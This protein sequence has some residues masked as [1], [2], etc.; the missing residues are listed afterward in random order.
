MNI[1]R[2]WRLVSVSLAVVFLT[3]GC[4]KLE[5]DIT[6]ANDD[7]VSGTMVF[8]IAK[9]ITD[10][11]AEDAESSPT[12]STQELFPNNADIESKPF[13]DGEFVGTTYTFDD[14][15]LAELAPEVGDDSALAIKR[16]G[17]NLVVSGLLDTGS[18][19][20]DLAT[21]PLAASL[22]EGIAELTSIKIAITLPGDIIQTNGEVDGQTITWT[23][24]FGEKLE[25]QAVAASP[26]AGPVNWL[27]IIGLS[28]LILGM[29]AGLAFWF[30]SKNKPKPSSTAKSGKST[31]ES[32]P[33]KQTKAEV[34]A[35]EALAL[36]PCYQKKRFAFP[37]I[38]ALALSLFA[39][40]LGLFLPAQDSNNS[41]DGKSSSATS[42]RDKDAKAAGDG[43]GE[44]EAAQ[45]TQA[46][47]PAPAQPAPAPPAPKPAPPA[48]SSKDASAQVADEASETEGQYYAREDAY[49]FWSN[50]WYSRS[51][52]IN[53]LVNTMGHTYADA[54]YGVDFQGIN[55]SVEAFGMAATLIGDSYY[56]YQSMFN[57]LIGEG[58]SAS[59]AEYGVNALEWDW[60]REAYLYGIDLFNAGYL[61][62]DIYN[63]LIGMGFSDA[64]AFY[65]S[66]F[67]VNPE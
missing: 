12:S 42:Q 23:G 56:S 49:Y 32:K 53:E 54:E 35:A 45:E 17:D 62:E 36:R 65:G 22:T 37:A 59:E 33:K 58:F 27:L 44:G 29:A 67:A 16:Q 14:L 57:A 21:N 8:A 7:T 13:D 30:V 15:P 40:A 55:W 25:L 61:E 64:E 51:G 5:M 60:F 3:T 19:E 6:V 41:A 66:Y 38:G 28:V 34:L 9:S 26:L 63:E 4:I 52:L 47:A 31:T 50:N 39:I 2:L 10:L 43:S 48:P 46:A 20:A 1:K 11:A 24:S 18:Y